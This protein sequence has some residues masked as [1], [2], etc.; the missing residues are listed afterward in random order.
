MTI[1]MLADDFASLRTG[2]ESEIRKNAFCL[3]SAALSLGE[4]GEV[5]ANELEKIIG[6]IGRIACRT[7]N[8]D[9]GFVGKNGVLS[10][11][12]NAGD[13]QKETA[14]NLIRLMESGKLRKNGGILFAPIF[15]NGGG[16]WTLLMLHPAK[17]GS[18]EGFFFSESD[19]SPLL[20]RN[21]KKNISDS[22]LEFGKAILDA[23]HRENSFIN[24][25]S[26][27]NTKDFRDEEAL[28]DALIAAAAELKATERIA[29]IEKEVSGKKIII[30]IGQEPTTGLMIADFL[31]GDIGIDSVP[32]RVHA[33]VSMLAMLA[34]L[35][36][37]I[38]IL[39]RQIDIPMKRLVNSVL[40][41]RDGNFNSSGKSNREDEL[42]ALENSIAQTAERLNIL[43]GNL[44]KTIKD[45]E[46]ALTRAKR[47]EKDKADLFNRVNHELKNPLHGIINYSRFGVEA[48]EGKIREYF[49]AIREN[50]IDLLDM[51]SELLNLA[52]NQMLS[53]PEKNFFDMKDILCEIEKDFSYLSEAKNIYVK[54]EFYPEAEEIEIEA[55]R[56]Q[57]KTALLNIVG[58]AMKFSPENSTITI[59]CE[60]NKENI[61]VSVSDEGPGI[62]EDKIDKIFAEFYRVKTHKDGSGLGLYIAKKIILA[63]NGMIYAVNDAHGR[64]VSFRIKLPM[65]G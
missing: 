11:S 61:T 41:L 54:K 53:A 32:M 39:S 20:K 30:I 2:P 38:V 46:A 21:L 22:S 33:V 3:S 42:G 13:G 31:V 50:S 62:P 1:K 27:L 57:I 14:K 63:H 28:T 56:K 43:Y 24:Y 4:I 8:D 9:F 34:G 40:S 18:A 44:Q 49:E 7:K 55:D 26:N 10:V 6:A 37:M 12:F 64:G 51:I 35:T 59:K 60:K 47:A 65:R 36:L 52:K 5:S 15:K 17:V 25:P 48:S 16:R 19:I 58:N 29:V 23:R 45:K